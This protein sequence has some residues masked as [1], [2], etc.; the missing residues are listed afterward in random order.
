MTNFL[1]ADILAAPPL[2]HA[3]WISPLLASAHRLKAANSL[4][5]DALLHRSISARPASGI[6][7]CKLLTSTWGD[8]VPGAAVAGVL[9]IGAG[10]A[11]TDM[12]PGVAGVPLAPGVAD[13]TAGVAGVPLAPGVAGVPLAP[14]VAGATAGVACVPEGPEGSH[15]KRRP[16]IP[17]AEWAGSPSFWQYC[18]GQLASPPMQ[19]CSS[20]IHKPDE[21]IYI[22]IYVYNRHNSRYLDWARMCKKCRRPSVPASVAHPIQPRP[23]L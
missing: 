21:Y 1:N 17:L 2:F 7:S 23:K 9:G 12:A 4:G 13:A 16:Q 20:W 19:P 6:A 5:W 18:Q 14:G 8:G 3:V 11:G 15:A 10:V 22:Y